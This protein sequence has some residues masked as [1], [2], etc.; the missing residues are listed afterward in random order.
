MSMGSKGS[1]HSPMIVR[2]EIPNII[3]RETVLS[4]GGRR[5]RESRQRPVA[6]RNLTPRL[7]AGDMSLQ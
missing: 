3:E 7:F 2:D 5:K 4:A 1:M 6:V